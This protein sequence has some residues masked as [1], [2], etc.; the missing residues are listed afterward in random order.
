[1]RV[2]GR[3]GRRRGERR[4]RGLQPRAA[5]VSGPPRS[6]E[7]RRRRDRVKRIRRNRPKGF[8]RDSLA[9]AWS[10]GLRSARG[11]RLGTARDSGLRRAR[12]PLAACGYLQEDASVPG[13][14]PGA[15]AV[16]GILSPPIS[17]RVS[18]PT[19][20]RSR[21]A[22]PVSATRVGPRKYGARSVRGL[23]TRIARA[24]TGL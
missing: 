7:G 11:W 5:G 13:G 24:S 23:V 16:R 4:P 15:R 18:F 17:A 9:T 6:P 22:C 10:W 21:P 3:A 2:G 1:M 14:V 12:D 8:Q 20:G 19:A